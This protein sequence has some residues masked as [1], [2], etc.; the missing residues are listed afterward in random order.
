MKAPVFHSS[1]CEGQDTEKQ[2]L[3]VYPQII[4]F[5]LIDQSLHR[6]KIALII[7]GFVKSRKNPSPSMGEGWGEGAKGTNSTTYIPLPFIPSH[8]GR[9]NVTFYEFII[10]EFPIFL[11]RHV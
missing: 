8:K 6:F 9:E 4:L 3:L 7:D 2:G 5:S 11:S 10:I 1:H